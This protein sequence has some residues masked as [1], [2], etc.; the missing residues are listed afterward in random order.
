MRCLL[1]ASV[2]LGM[3]YDNVRDRFGVAPGA[4]RFLRCHACGSA[5]LESPPSTEALAALYPERYT[6]NRADGEPSFVRSTLAALE[7][8]LFYG[9][10]YRRRVAIFRRLTGLR[11]GRVLEIGCGSGLLLV[12]LRNAGFEVEGVELSASDAARGR[13]RYGLS[14][15]EGRVE[16]LPFEPGRYDAVIL[17]NVLEHILDP[18][19]LARR[20]FEIVRPGGCLVAG[21]P[22]VDSAWSRWLG[23]R[24]GAVTEAPRHVS[25]PSF[26][27]MVTLFGR[28]GFAEV[29]S[30]PAPLMDRAGDLVLSLLP[31]AATTVSYGASAGVV[32]LARRAAA[33]LM[34]GPA[35][36]LAAVEQ[37]PWRRP[38]RTEAM[39]FCGRK[40]EGAAHVS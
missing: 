2:K 23:A 10:T 30:A 15:R 13:A 3:L 34:M 6:F 7:W 32:A 39:L 35:V 14:I 22:V 21:V 33:A 20:A 27:G 26:D 40:P 38:P 28:A 8:R 11:H 4:Y 25:I 1:C 12:H 24:W 18:A 37:L 36:A 9:P 5:T 16:L 31:S 19:A 29:T 17:V